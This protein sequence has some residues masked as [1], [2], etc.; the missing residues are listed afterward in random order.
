M[1]SSFLEILKA[2]LEMVLGN[3]L[4]LTL[5]EQGSRVGLDVFKRSFPDSVVLLFCFFFSFFFS[6]VGR[7]E[8]TC[9]FC[10]LNPFS[11]LE[12]RFHCRLLDLK[13]YMII[14]LKN[15][16]TCVIPKGFFFFFFFFFMENF[17]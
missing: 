5:I 14:Y 8:V 17:E 12:L 7:T 3:L 13:G 10:F 9:P 2:Q 1:E 11:L 6:E 16:A 15:K 4:W